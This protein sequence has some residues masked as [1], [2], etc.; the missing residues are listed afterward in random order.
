VPLQPVWALVATV[1]GHCCEQLNGHE[2]TS[3]K[4]EEKLEKIDWEAII[5]EKNEEKMN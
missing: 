5:S 3:E 4:S 2:I 1:L